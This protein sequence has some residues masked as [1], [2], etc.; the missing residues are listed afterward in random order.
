[1]KGVKKL[2][3]DLLYTLHFAALNDGADYFPWQTS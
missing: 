3:A 2:V 1:M